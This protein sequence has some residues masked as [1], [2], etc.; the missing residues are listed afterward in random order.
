MNDPKNRREGL[1]SDHPRTFL[2]NRYVYPVLSRRAGGISIGVNLSRDKRCNFDC[3]YCQVDRSIAGHP[4]ALNV[5]RLRE[6]LDATVEQVTAGTIYQR[7]PFRRVPPE[8]RR[9]NDIALSG[10]GEPTLAA[11]F[12][13]AVAACAEVRRRRGLDEVKL[14][15]I[16][17][18]SRLHLP[19]VAA[20]LETLDANNGEIWA[21]LD[22]G[23][24][25]R[26]EQVARTSVPWRRV[27]DNLRRAA[28]ARPI[29]VQ[30]LFMR[31][32]GRP[33]IEDEQEAYC[34][35]LAEIVAGGGQIKLVQVYTIARPPAEDRV[36]PLTAA[37]LEALAGRI[38]QRTGLHAVAFPGA[39]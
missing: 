2:E 17:N 39:C 1:T 26:F 9:L 6:E 19:P 13:E 34:R 38:R 18:A 16:T 31:I 8:L 11:R 5:A 20:A 23:T 15:L 10:D 37:E 14:V 22:A 35:R 27:L 24:E 30:S 28:Q 12:P 25:G 4:E 7:E 36:G 33:P 32:D 21:K 29:V 3:I